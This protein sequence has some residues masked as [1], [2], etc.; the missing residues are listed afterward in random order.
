MRLVLI[1]DSHHS[2]PTVDSLGREEASQKDCLLY[3][4]ARPTKIEPKS[5]LV[6]A[7]QALTA[8]SLHA[9]AQAT[10]ERP[11]DRFVL[12]VDETHRSI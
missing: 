8:Q 10:K 2:T 5:R 3:Q 9:G 4:R 12:D 1:R 6:R 11:R 7:P